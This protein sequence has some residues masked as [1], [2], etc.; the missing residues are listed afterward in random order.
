MVFFYR[1]KFGLPMGLPFS[2]IFASLF[3]EFLESSPFKFINTQ[4]FFLFP[5]YR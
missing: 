4:R 3:L 1:Q 2:G 5:L